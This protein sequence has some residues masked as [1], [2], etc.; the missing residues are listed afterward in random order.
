MV[1]L[2]VSIS[3]YVLYLGEKEVITE[4]TLNKNATFVA[5]K[6]KEVEILVNEKVLGIDKL[7]SRFK[8]TRLQGSD[9]Q[10]IEK[11]QNYASAM[12][13]DSFVIGF[14]NGDAFWSLVNN[15]WPNHKY[16]T[17]VTTAGW[18]KA[19]RNA[20]NVTVT[21]PY[22]GSGGE[23]YWITIGDTIKDGI[24]TTDMTLQFLSDIVKQ[25]ANI[26]GTT[27][28]ILNQDTTVLATSSPALELAK[29]ANEY[30]WFKTLVNKAVAHNNTMEHYQLN[31]QD[32]IFFSQRIN[33]GD[34]QWYFCIG[35]DTSVIFASLDDSRNTAILTAFISVVISMLIAFTIIQL[36][37]RPILTLKETITGL[38]SGDAD[39][40]Q[41][42]DV[43]TDDDLGQIAQGV[44]KFI[45]NL[46]A[47]MLEIQDAT[48]TLHSGVERMQDQSQR[49]DSILQSHVAE[50]EQ[51]VTAIEE[52]N[53][54]A[55]AMASD[56]SN[57]AE[58]THQANKT[59]NESRRIV[60]QSQHT[61]SEL[62]NDV[63]GAVDN[64]SDMN[65]KTQSINNILEVIG[66]IAE[67]TNLLALNA[68]IEAARAGEQGRGFAVVADEV[69][70]LASRTKDST[71]EVETALDSLLKGTQ[72]VV[73]SMDNTKAKC[74]ETAD[75]SGDVANSLDSMSQFVNDIND[76]STQI[77]TAAEEQ[78]SVT[79]ELTR[80]MTAISG[81][82]Q[83]LE[84]NG[85]QALQDAQ[86][87]ANVNNQLSAIVKRFKL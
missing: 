10:I 34:K 45:E 81:I 84:G 61:V 16:N 73:D 83:E 48:Q 35:V 68:A 86:E 18:Y 62:I 3:S 44:N 2:S 36:L 52:M 30:T 42:I 1:G 54:T 55:E 53:S 25:S 71:E 58:L 64:V 70:N 77:A 85:Q 5:N 39:L 67:Q 41:R 11:A 66:G 46:H 72:V 6:A 9:E 79:Q 29:K 13:L 4:E 59:G 33:I 60:Q 76:L 74:Q 63:D 32:K 38:S 14:E 51:V 43:K 37:Y 49:N 7:A 19:V 22:L 20:S 57:T 69:R 65:N 87:I 56:A 12:N 21:E 24:I 50:T 15:A 31:D 82:V 26:P 75:S 8:N 23:F 17:D 40:T 27:A 47:M 78:S 80:N 28:V